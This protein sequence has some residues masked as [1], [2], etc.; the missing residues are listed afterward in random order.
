MPLYVTKHYTMKTFGRGGGGCIDPDLTIGR[1]CV[2]SFMPQPLYLRVK[3][4][5]YL[6]DR[7]LRGWAL[8]PVWTAW[9]KKNLH[10][11][12]TRTLTPWPP[13]LSFTSQFSF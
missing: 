13:N 10:S 9:R 11:T 1:R 12:G 4:Q 6:L 8:E 5:Q 7:R 3:D 2:A